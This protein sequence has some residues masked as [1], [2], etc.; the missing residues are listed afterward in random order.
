MAGLLEPK[1]STV[2]RDA[3]AAGS[4]DSYG[5]ASHRW[6]RVGFHVGHRGR[7]TATDRDVFARLQ[8]RAVCESRSHDDVVRAGLLVSM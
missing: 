2:A 3:V 7:S 5:S 4:F 1:S 8:L 6:S